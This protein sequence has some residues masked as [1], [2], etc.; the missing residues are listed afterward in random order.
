MCPKSS[1]GIFQTQNPP[2]YFQT[3]NNFNDKL[4]IYSNVTK[5][6]S[7]YTRHKTV[8]KVEWE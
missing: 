7:V 2:H 3:L 5:E 1:L 4:W 8:E 6:L